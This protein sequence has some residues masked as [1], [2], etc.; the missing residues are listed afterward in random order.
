[1]KTVSTAYNAC[2]E[3]FGGKGSF[4]WIWLFPLDPSWKDKDELFGFCIID[5]TRESV[6]I[7]ESE[8]TVENS[9]C[10]CW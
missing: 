5:P 8:W 9:F 1:M 6:S 2:A 7:S 3:V 4:Q 10:V